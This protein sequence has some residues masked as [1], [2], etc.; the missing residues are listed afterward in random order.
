MKNRK[1]IVLLLCILILSLLFLPSCREKQKEDEDLSSAPYRDASLPVEERVD[2]L[3]SRMSLNEKLGQMACVERMFLQQDSDIKEYN[4]GAVLSGGGSAPDPNKPETW[5][6]MYNSFQSAALSTRFGIPILYGID[7]VHGNNSVYGA[8]IFPHNIGLGATRDPELMEEIGRI[9]AL[10]VAAP[11]IDW[12]YA[13]CVAVPQDE[14]W[15]RTYE[16][17]SEYAPLVGELG[18]AYI[19][20]LQG[21]KLGSDPLRVIA[22]A[23][24]YLGDGGTLKGED[25]ENT[26]APE[27][28]MRNIYL[29]PYRAAVEAGVGSVMIS[30]SSLNGEKMHA[31]TYLITDVLKGELGFNGLVVSDWGGIDFLAARY[32][33]CVRMSILAGIDMI[34][35]PDRYEEFLLT[36]KALVTE[37]EIPMERIDDAVHRI[38]RIKF[39]MGLFEAPYAD[40]SLVNLIGSTE[41]REVA[42]KAVRKSLVLLKNR[43]NI[44]PLS[45]KIRSIFVAGKSANSVG[46][47]CGGWTLTWQGKTD[48]TIPGTTI[49]DSIRS[50]VS[51]GTK[52]TFN[53]NGEGASGY[54]VAI[55]VI[56]ELPYAEWFG[57]K[58]NINLSVVDVDAINNCRKAGVPVVV[59]LI[60]GRPMVVTEYI[61][62]W[63]AFIAAW[64]P[65]TEGKG[66]TDILFGDYK[67]LGKLSFTW[68]KSS[69]QLPINV[70]DDQYEPLFPYGFGL[71]YK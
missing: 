61:A 33:D 64:L 11:G 19:R 24:H 44:L 5:I 34:M 8:T 62:H 15:G 21:L 69:G 70:G 52:V 40:K 18:A 56:G 41:H 30:F 31:H 38:L 26:V 25:R 59:I 16:G 1:A 50:T 17:Y 13:P 57:D 37:K 3:L 28:E 14:R 71:T 45:K 48:T 58:E 49:L 22:C 67:P 2:D 32:R 68:P 65:G 42:R 6:D 4:I 46:N 7:A 55:V 39:S 35:I 9:T 43:N 10:E 20:G 36:L 51:P 12:N 54:D 53:E 23:K 29:A 47:Q 63:D 66:V 60:S 27:E